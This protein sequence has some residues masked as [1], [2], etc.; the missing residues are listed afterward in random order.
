[1]VIIDTA[2]GLA[3]IGEPMLVALILLMHLLTGAA[4]VKVF[5][6]SPYNPNEYVHILPPDELQ[7]HPQQHPELLREYE[8]EVEESIARME[9]E[10]DK[11]QELMTRFAYCLEAKG[12]TVTGVHQLRDSAVN[13]L[14]IQICLSVLQSQAMCTIG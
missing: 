13:R 3:I 6:L 10:I 7:Q 9:E 1:M 11:H 2:H 5:L 14:R 12:V 8:V 4:E